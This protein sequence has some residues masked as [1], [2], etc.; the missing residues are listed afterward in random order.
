MK[1]LE[2]TTTSYEVV[3]HCRYKAEDLLC[4]PGLVAGGGESFR[5][6]ESGGL[7]KTSLAILSRLEI[8][9]I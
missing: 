6:P 2:P 9:I 3:I 1:K 5:I 4:F 7:A 8:R